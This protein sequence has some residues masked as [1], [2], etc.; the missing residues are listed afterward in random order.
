MKTI[1]SDPK[2]LPCGKKVIQ[3]V[4]LYTNQPSQKAGKFFS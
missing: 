3:N 1:P 2:T 4:L